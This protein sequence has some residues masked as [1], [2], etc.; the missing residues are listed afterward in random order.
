MVRP[1][2]S[3][4]QP[5]YIDICFI[6]PNL[7][8]ELLDNFDSKPKTI[9]IKFDLESRPQSATDDKEYFV[10]FIADNQEL[11]RIK[12]DLEKELGNYPERKPAQARGELVAETFPPVWRECSVDLWVAYLCLRLTTVRL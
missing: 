11:E 1:S 2:S 7:S 9:R 10:D 12:L 5:E 6:E 3:N 4:L 8:F